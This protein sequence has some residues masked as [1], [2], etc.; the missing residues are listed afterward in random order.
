MTRYRQMENNELSHG[1]LFLG[2]GLFVA[3]L[4]GATGTVS[5]LS[6]NGDKPL[7][8]GPLQAKEK[9]MAE[10]E[11]KLESTQ[12]KITATKPDI[13][14]EIA[15][16]QKVIDQKNETQQ[17]VKDLKDEIGTLENLFVKINKY[18]GD[19]GGNRY[20]AGNCTWYVKSMRP[21]ISNSWGNA[22]T[23]YSNAAAQGWKVGSTPKKGAVATS[24]SGWAG[25]VAYVLGVSKDA[26]WVTIREMNY[27]GLYSMNT[28]TVFYTEFQ[29]IYQLD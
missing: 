22:N 14:K 23:W 5:A 16:A 20:A 27:G 19:S 2:V 24:T 15:E 25:H 3:I 21:D 10:L 4:L 9:R 13:E 8:F 12:E 1:R 28:R 18:A 6:L 11:E 17:S 26:Q 7:N 29:Y